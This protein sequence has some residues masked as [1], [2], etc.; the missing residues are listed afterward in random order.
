MCDGS[1]V[2][3]RQQQLIICAIIVLPLLGSPLLRESPRLLLH[4]DGPLLEA[5][6]A[7]E[8]VP[9]GSNAYVSSSSDVMDSAPAAQASQAL[10]RRVKMFRTAVLCA[11]WFTVNLLFYGLD[12][13]VGACDP[14]E[15]CNLYMHGVL[16]ALADLPG[17][18]RDLGPL[19]ARSIR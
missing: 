18:A 6:A 15:G 17:C 14:T 11:V 8:G 19:T 2:P 5:D 10:S 12:Y 3:W 7:T 16:T 4:G 9:T 1:D 13:A